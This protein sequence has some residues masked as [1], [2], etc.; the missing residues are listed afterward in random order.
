MVSLFD[1]N[2]SG[3]VIHHQIIV[4]VSEKMAVYNSV[5]SEFCSVLSNNCTLAERKRCEIYIAGKISFFSRYI[6]IGKLKNI[7]TII[8]RSQ[9]QFVER[10]IIEHRAVGM[11]SDFFKID[12]KF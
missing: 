10:F 9:V 5:S 8:K 1:Q 7:Q 4:I 2:I 6:E 11:I 3:I 12:K